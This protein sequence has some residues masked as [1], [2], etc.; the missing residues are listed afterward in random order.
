MAANTKDKWLKQEDV[1][2]ACESIKARGE[3]VS[4]NSVYDELGERGSYKTIQKFIVIWGAE[5]SEQLEEIKNLPV[6]AEI[7][8]SI[9]GIGKKLLKTYWNEAKAK[10]DA[11]LDIQR[12]ALKQAEANANN[13]VDEITLFSGKQ[14]ETITVLREQLAEQQTQLTNEKNKTDKLNELISQEHDKLNTIEKE[15]D[16]SIQEVKNIKDK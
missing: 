3:R 14:T 4:T 11:E 2:A 5:N 13:K 6:S 15:R 16:L 9:E 10:A 1:H 7:P 12:E 8:E